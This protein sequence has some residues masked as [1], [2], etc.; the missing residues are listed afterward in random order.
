MKKA[1]KAKK[2][3][4]KTKSLSKAAGKQL[5]NFLNRTYNAEGLLRDA[6]AH[7]EAVEKKAK[8]TVTRNGEV[9]NATEAG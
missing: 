1:K 5:G 4:Y 2:K 3:P 8:Q 9:A 6:A 7:A